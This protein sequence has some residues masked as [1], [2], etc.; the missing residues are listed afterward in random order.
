M[1]ILATTRTKI[2][3]FITSLLRS[4]SPNKKITQKKA[5]RRKAFCSAGFNVLQTCTALCNYVQ[6]VS[7]IDTPGI[8]ESLGVAFLQAFGFFGTPGHPYLASAYAVVI[9]TRFDI[10]N[11]H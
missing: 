9:I 4:R 11:H 10:L 7:T 8:L 1:Q 5:N 2:N 6:H 3:R